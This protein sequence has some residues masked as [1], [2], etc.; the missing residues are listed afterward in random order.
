MTEANSPYFAAGL[1]DGAADRARITQCPGLDPLGMDG[2]K[3]WSLMYRRGYNRAYGDPERH[4][5]CR[6][7][8]PDLFPKEGSVPARV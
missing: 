5:P 6:A 1:A 4:M 3:S 8:C 2:E 7:C